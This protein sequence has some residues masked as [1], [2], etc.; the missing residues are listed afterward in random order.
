MLVN[1]DQQSHVIKKPT[2]ISNYE[3]IEIDQSNTHFSLFVLFVLKNIY[4]LI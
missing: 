4:F 1:N 3:V 2:W